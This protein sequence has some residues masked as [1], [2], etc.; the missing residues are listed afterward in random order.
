MTLRTAAT[1]TRP[2]YEIGEI[3]EVR[4]FG[5]W[6]RCVVLRVYG[7]E[8]H[9]RLR[10][11]KIDRMMERLVIRHENDPRGSGLNVINRA[12]KV[13]KLRSDA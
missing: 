10:T 2:V 8:S 1:R 11:G 6:K 4:M 7:E 3:V 13:R 12:D 9:R 5:E